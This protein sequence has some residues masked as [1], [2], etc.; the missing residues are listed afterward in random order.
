MWKC[1]GD[2]AKIYVGKAIPGVFKDPASRVE[3]YG[4][5]EVPVLY[6]YVCALQCTERYKYESK[7]SY[8]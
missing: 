7:L 4:L 8:Y 1:G 5:F 3:P 2:Y 6:E